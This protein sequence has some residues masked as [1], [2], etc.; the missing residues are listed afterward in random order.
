MKR[1]SFWEIFATLFVVA[2]LCVGCESEDPT[3]ASPT[4]VTFEQIEPLSCMGGEGEI[5]YRIHTPIEGAELSLSASEEPW[6]Y[7]LSVDRERE[8]IHF[9]FDTYSA[10]FGAP[11]RETSF[12]VSYGDLEPYTVVVKQQGPRECFAV[13]YL[14][15]APTYFRAK[16]TPE[17]QSLSY[18]IGYTTAADIAKAGSLEK[19]INTRLSGYV[20]SYYGD[21]L[22]YYLLVGTYPATEEQEP[23]LCEWDHEPVDPRFYAVGVSRNSAGRPMLT[24]APQLFELTLPATPVLNLEKAFEV[25]KEAGELLIPYTLENPLEGEKL[26][27]DVESSGGWITAVEDLGG[28]IKVSYA[29]NRNAI[30]RTTKIEV[31]YRY[32]TSH[33]LTITQQADLEQE[34]LT[35]EMEVVGNHFNH[36]LV[37]LTPSDKG[38]KYVLNAISKSDFVGYPYEGSDEKLWQ[39]ELSNAYY[40]V[41]I[42]TGDQQACRVEVAASEYVGWEW[43]L[44]V[45]AVSDDETMAISE[46]KKLLVQVVDDTP[47]L[48][49]SST[50]MQLSAEGGVV[51]VPYTLENPI[52][53]GDL[54]ID[55]LPMNSYNVIDAQSLEVDQTKGVVRFT[56]NPYDASQRYHDATIFIAYFESASS[57]RSICGASLRLEQQAPAN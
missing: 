38:V 55:G 37:N 47:Q 1:F 20:D 53:G 29:R 52:E 31:G 26:S 32:A 13:E 50:K 36:L 43:Y 22:D 19:L 2:S 34:P 11:E 17:D 9:Y 24:T 4:G 23:I 51:E 16:V 18:M 8:V 57:T 49:F 5:A 14:E 41:P 48:S 56:V 15:L 12:Q 3:P 7:N 44:Y 39:T 30:E 6:L 28:Q 25:E 27:F 10:E 46:V 33:T 40:E 35:F 21:I 42:Y 54:R 45:Y